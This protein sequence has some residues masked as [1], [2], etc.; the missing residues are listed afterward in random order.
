MFSNHGRSQKYEHEF[1]INSRLIPQAALL[2]VCLPHLDEWNQSRRRVS[3][4]TMKPCR[5]PQVTIPGV[6]PET[7]PVTTSMSSSS[8]IETGLEFLATISETG[9]HY[10]MSLNPSPP[11]ATSIRGPAIPRAG[12]LRHMLSLRCRP[13]LRGSPPVVAAK[14]FLAR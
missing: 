2:D 10:P 1:E 8:R 9:I 12:M 13:S 3:S 5:C 4:G 7:E 11:T 14:K 6:L